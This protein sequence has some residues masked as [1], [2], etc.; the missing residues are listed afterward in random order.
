M[1]LRLFFNG[2]APRIPI[3][4]EGKSKASDKLGKGQS[5]PVV[6]SSSAGTVEQI[7]GADETAEDEAPVTKPASRKG[8]RGAMRVTIEPEEPE[9]EEVPEP[10]TRRRGRKGA[11]V[12]DDQEKENNKGTATAS[13]PINAS[14]L[15]VVKEINN[16]QIMNQGI[17]DGIEGF[18]YDLEMITHEQNKNS[19]I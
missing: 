2:K 13:K 15:M 14:C 19:S 3:P 16:R 5:E 18:S 17:C 12:A 11:K 7:E 1:L 4:S 6:T 9:E 8:R 10:S